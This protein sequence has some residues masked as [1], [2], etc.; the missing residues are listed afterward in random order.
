MVFKIAQ[1]P[2]LQ[3]ESV[4]SSDETEFND[5]D[6]DDHHHHHHHIAMHCSLYRTAAYVIGKQTS[7]TT[8]YQ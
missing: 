5:D 8:I 4:S 7:K 6:D 1:Q 3:E 2:T